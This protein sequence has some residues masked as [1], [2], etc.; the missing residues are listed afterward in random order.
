MELTTELLSEAADFATQ[1]WPDRER[2][3]IGFVIENYIL[4]DR[5]AALVHMTNYRIDGIAL[6]SPRNND[7]ALPYDVGIDA[8]YVDPLWAND[9]I[10]IELYKECEEWAKQKGST[11]LVCCCELSDDASRRFYL[12]YGFD[13]IGKMI[14]F[15]KKLVD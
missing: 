8:F 14:H 1:M 15:K 3:Y 5:G 2:G 9:G 6:L 12:K 4:S 7:D 11:N 13:E 10:D